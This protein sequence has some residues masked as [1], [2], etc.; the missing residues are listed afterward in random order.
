M[1]LLLGMCY[2]HFQVWLGSDL[3]LWNLF[4][5]DRLPEEVVDIADR[6]D[7]NMDEVYTED[8]VEVGMYKVI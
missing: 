7:D 8:M 3:D 2:K 4:V 6:V 5:V 1:V